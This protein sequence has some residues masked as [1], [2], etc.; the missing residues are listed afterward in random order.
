MSLNLLKAATIAALTFS[1][2]ANGVMLEVSD[3]D[4]LAQIENMSSKDKGTY[5]G[6]DFIQALQAM[7]DYDKAMGDGDDI[8]I[9][10]DALDAADE[11]ADII[12]AQRGMWDDVDDFE[13]YLKALEKSLELA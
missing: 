1:C 7:R 13:E 9:E 5:S 8:D 2:T 11:V 10:D 3:T 12:A 6:S 4:D